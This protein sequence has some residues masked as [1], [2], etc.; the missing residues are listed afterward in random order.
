MFTGLVEEKGQVNSIS[1]S[2]KNFSIKINAE[3]VMEGIKIGDSVSTNGVCLTVSAFDKSS[4]T[5]DVM[6]ETYRRTNLRA[7]KLGEHVNLER[8]MMLGDRFGGHIVSGHVDGVGEIISFKKEANAIWVT[9]KAQPEIMKYILMKG[10]VCTDGISLT[11]AH[12]EKEY[13]KVSLIPETARATTIADK[14]TGDLINIE[15]DIVGKYIERFMLF[16][17]PESKS[18]V[19]EE[20]LMQNGFI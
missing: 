12:V 7:L 8:A 9:I 19:T 4:F 13:F 6:P 20:L 10:S 1:I 5:A 16:K 3:T 17:E 2:G 18:H 14:K 11:V 15:C